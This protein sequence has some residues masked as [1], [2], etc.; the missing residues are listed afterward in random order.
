MK[1][2][3]QILKKEWLGAEN[4]ELTYVLCMLN[5]EIAF[6]R[7]FGGA[8]DFIFSVM[9]KPELVDNVVAELTEA[10]YSVEVDREDGS[11]I[12]YLRVLE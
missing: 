7:E 8:L 12:V 11:D 2:K 10:G 9:Y 5:S 3:F 1:T 4:W 6:Q